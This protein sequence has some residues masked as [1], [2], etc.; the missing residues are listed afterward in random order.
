MVIPVVVIIS[1]GMFNRK[2]RV[3]KRVI[4]LLTG[5]NGRIS[6]ND[7]RYKTYRIDYFN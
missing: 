5:S 7:R 2:V 3:L 4:S 1:K 6:N